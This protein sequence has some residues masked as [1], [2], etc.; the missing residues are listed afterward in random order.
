MDDES[1]GRYLEHIRSIGPCYLHM[2]PS[3]ANVLVRFLK[4]S[5]LPPPSNVRGLLIGSENM[6]EED[7][8]AAEATFGVRY[9]TWYGHSEKLV[10][11]AEC[12]RSSVYHVLP[13]YG[14]CELVDENG[15]P[16]SRPGERGEIVGTGFMNRVMP[17]IRYRTGDHA[18][19]A[20]DRC[21]ECGRHHLLLEDVRGHR[22][23]EMLVGKSGALIPWTAVNTH[24]DTFDG[25]RQFQF[26]QTEVGRATLRVVPSSP[27]DVDIERIRK[28][29][30]GRLQGQLELDVQVVPEIRLT[31]RGKSVFVD[32]RLDTD[33][34]L[35]SGGPAPARGPGGPPHA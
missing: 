19:H 18:T 16:V 21:R 31:E 26:A 6:Y 14:Y 12:E 35:R 10:L 23:Q 5:R 24:E 32:Q 28:D 4:R 29:M 34:M 17:F 25:V 27:G 11:A 2:Y 13:T 8:R 9:F 1:I 30:A 3:A 22:T 20:G 7:R 15:R 33:Q